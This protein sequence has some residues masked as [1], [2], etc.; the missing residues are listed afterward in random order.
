[1]VHGTSL[2]AVLSSA[3]LLIHIT[4]F[5]L[6]GQ[7]SSQDVSFYVFLI[8]YSRSKIARPTCTYLVRKFSSSKNKS[9][10]QVSVARFWE[11]HE[12]W[13][14]SGKFFTSLENTSFSGNLKLSNFLILCS[15][16]F[17]PLGIFLA[18]FGKNLGK[19]QPDLL[20]TLPSL[21]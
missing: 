15:R 8:L 21:Q 20:A 17:L 18:K 14:N 4:N 3:H 13:E 11:I 2:S 12:F 10:H 19:F 1:M 6:K 7:I 16:R 9:Y 5:G